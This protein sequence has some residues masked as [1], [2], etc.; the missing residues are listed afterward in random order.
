[1]AFSKEWVE[2]QDNIHGSLHTLD[3]GLGD[4]AAVYK[5]K[6]EKELA[7]TKAARALD[8]CAAGNE[9]SAL[10]LGS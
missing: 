8:V 10:M 1:M 7:Q 2:S 6:T 3:A 5:M 9:A 4:K